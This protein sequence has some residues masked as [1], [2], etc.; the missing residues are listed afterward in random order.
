MLLVV[1]VNQV[2]ELLMKQELI[3]R[4]YPYADHPADAEPL[5]TEP[6]DNTV[7]G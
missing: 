1:L 4:Y 6:S 2:Q 5:E 7:A 3:D